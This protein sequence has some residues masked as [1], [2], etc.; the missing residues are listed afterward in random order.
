MSDV[1]RMDFINSLPP[2]LWAKVS[3]TWW[4]VY[5]I[6]V[7]TGLFRIDVCGLLQACDMADASEFRDSAGT[8]H[9]TETFYS[10]YEEAISNEY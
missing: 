4:P 7:E 5:D 9:D 2:P 3:G 6:E 1:L 8:S 10:D